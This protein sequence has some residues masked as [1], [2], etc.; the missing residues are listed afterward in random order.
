MSRSVFNRNRTRSGV[1]D[2]IISEL[3]DVDNEDMEVEF[4]GYMHGG[5]GFAL[6]ILNLESISERTLQLWKRVIEGKGL[7]PCIETDMMSGKVNIKCVE[8]VRQS[9]KPFM[10]TLMY[11]S[12]TLTF[13]YIL[14][15]RHQSLK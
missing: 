7:N 5:K 4:K 6:E 15:N 9:R 2:K 14:W 3:N 13:I 11:L 1:A 12:L 10:K 8:N